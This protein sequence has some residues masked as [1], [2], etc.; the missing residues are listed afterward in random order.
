MENNDILNH[1]SLC[2]KTCPFP[3]LAA[4]VNNDIP[5][6]A[7]IYVYAATAAV[8]SADA[9]GGTQNESSVNMGDTKYNPLEYQAYRPALLSAGRSFHDFSA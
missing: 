7:T 4:L 2:K 3:V 5:S 8:I 9:H 6:R 1:E